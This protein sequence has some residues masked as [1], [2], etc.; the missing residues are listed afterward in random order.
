MLV[1]P[2]LGADLAAGYHANQDAQFHP[3]GE[4]GHWQLWG[5]DGPG[6]GRGEGAQPRF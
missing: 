1:G 4:T 5:V 6:G 2:I 3:F